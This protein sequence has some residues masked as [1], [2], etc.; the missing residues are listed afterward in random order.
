MSGHKFKVCI[1]CGEN[2]IHCARGLCHNCYSKMDY[3]EHQR[4][5]RESQNVYK[6]N[7]ENKKKMLEYH[8]VYYATPEQV[9]KERIRKI[10]YREN[11]KEL[12][13]AKWNIKSKTPHYRKLA[14]LRRNK[15]RANLKNIVHNFTYD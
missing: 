13:K 15:R 11:N 2:K 7:P 3:Y 12:L 5:R 6:N 1:E 9:E 10:K 14:A 4:I 8:K